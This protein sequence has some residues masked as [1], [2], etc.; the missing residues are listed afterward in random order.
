MVT[1]SDPCQDKLGDRKGT[2]ENIFPG[3][4][5]GYNPS[6]RHFRRTIKMTEFSIENTEIQEILQLSKLQGGSKYRQQDIYRILD[7]VVARKDSAKTT[8]LERQGVEIL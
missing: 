1:G 2:D 5:G 8:S 7:R 6:E 3:K 4:P